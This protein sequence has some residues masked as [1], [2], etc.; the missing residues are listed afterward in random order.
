VNP[1]ELTLSNGDEIAA[2]VRL[3]LV[4]GV[5]PSVQQRLVAAVGSASEVL[6]APSS[7]IA[8][9]AG[10]AAAECLAK[11]ADGELVEATLR[12]RELPNHRVLTIGDDS[13]PRLLREI[14]DPPTVLYTIG[15]PQ[16]LD[17]PAFA[18]V[19]SRNATPAGARD[20]QSFALA[21]SQAGLCIV[22]GLALGIDA[23]AHRGGLAGPGST[24]A[25]MGTGA[26]RIYPRRNRELAHEIAATGCLVT[27]FPL[28]LGALAGNFP[29]RNRLISGLARG[30]LVVEAADRSGSLITARLAAEQGRDVFAIP[31]SIHSPLS[32][33]CHILIK[34][35][36]KLVDRVED[37]LAELG[38]EVPAAQVPEPARPA[39]ASNRLLEAMGFAPVTVDRMAQL[40][41]EGAASISAQLSQLEIEGRV[42]ALAGG[43]FQQRE[44]R[45]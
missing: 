13:Y 10:H 19:G 28:G 38:L 20:G 39:A 40:V 29:R 9:I 24:I 25:V 23:S 42:E 26:D 8:A 11:G 30:V 3:A 43:W 27:E 12:W 15:R 18:I 45:R 4:P 22:S 35:G 1:S 21:L 17:A 44:H 6:A 7:R 14:H 5:S 32:K 36:A 16:L 37:I 2:W 33:G 31:G 41:G 34:E